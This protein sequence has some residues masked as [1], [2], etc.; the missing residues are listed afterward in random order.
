[1]PTAFILSNTYTADLAAYAGRL[2]IKPG[3]DAENH[4]RTVKAHKAEF[5]QQLKSMFDDE[6]RRGKRGKAKPRKGMT[7]L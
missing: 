1:M 6:V 5:I 3:S 7:R 4:L 2:F